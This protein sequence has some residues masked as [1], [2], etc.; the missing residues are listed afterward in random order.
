MAGVGRD[1][2][3]RLQGVGR[4]G[5]GSGWLGRAAGVCRVCVTCMGEGLGVVL[6]PVG[7]LLRTLDNSSMVAVVDRPSGLTVWGVEFGVG[8]GKAEQKSVVRVEAGRL[9]PA[10]NSEMSVCCS[11]SVPEVSFAFS[12]LSLT[13]PRGCWMRI[14]V[15]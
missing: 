12:V 13:I 7:E 6:A 2:I 4:Y 5:E 1:G 10:W 9:Y 8:C 15:V 14:L 11:S 3:D